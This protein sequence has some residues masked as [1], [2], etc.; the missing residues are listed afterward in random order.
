VIEQEHVDTFHEW[1]N[2]L[3]DN[4]GIVIR[5]KR[6]EVAM[7]L[8]CVFSEGHLLLED[9][10]GTGKTSLAKTIANS[11]R[12]E[13]DRI[14]F[15]P[16]LLPSDVTGGLIYHQGTGEFSFRP[17][18]I[19]AN[20]VLADEINRASPKTQSAL[21][22][23]MEERHV[24]VGN[25]T[26]PVPRPF[27]VLATQNPDEQEGTYRLPEAQLDR[28]MMRSA[29]GYPDHDAEVDVLGDVADGVDPSSIE[30]VMSTD[31]VQRLI[32]VAGAVHVSAEIRSYIVRLADATRRMDDVLRLGV[33]TRGC[34]ALMKG[35]RTL[36]AA[37]GRTFVTADDVKS[38]AHAVMEHRM[39]LTPQAELDGVRTAELVENVLD[40]VDAPG[41]VR[42]GN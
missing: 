7:A 4:V 33:S 36:A 41:A 38:V 3:L 22:E 2:L 17:G 18:P 32:R 13:W 37:Q 25:K 35:S 42:V 20:V 8:V 31:D 5:G 6:Q 24:T 16:D 29:L 15:T 26:R 1:F 30:A 11:I 23:V 9:H 10:P 28:F 14:Q 40:A 19:F 39:L 21:L 34:I 27:V 12:G